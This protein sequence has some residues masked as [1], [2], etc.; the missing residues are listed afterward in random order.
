MY[1]VSCDESRVAESDN[2]VKRR[3]NKIRENIYPYQHQTQPGD[4]KIG[5]L[6]HL[7]RHQV[8]SLSRLLSSRYR[9]KRGRRV[10]K[11][12]ARSGRPRCS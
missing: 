12:R 7:K 4:I 8:E 11:L 10:R 9:L 2:R 3:M 1:E 5:K 6:F